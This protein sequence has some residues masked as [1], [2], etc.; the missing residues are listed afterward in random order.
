[1]HTTKIVLISGHI[2]SGKSRL[3]D[4]LAQEF[5]FHRI[6]TNEILKAY[7][8]QNSLPVGRLDLQAYG[9]QR[10]KETDEKWVLHA[11]MEAINNGEN[12]RELIVDAVHTWGQIRHVREQF[13][14]P[15]IHV[16]LT[17]SME[18]LRRRF[19]DAKNA[20]REHDK[21]LSYEQ[22]NLNKTEH[23][24]KHL[25][26]E[27]D[28]CVN[29]DRSD[30]NDT[31]VQI[32]ARI[33][34]YAP[35]SYRCVDVIVG[36]QYGSEG[37]GQIAAYLAKNYG[38]LMRVG[39]PNAGHTVKSE[40]GKYTYHH[41]PSGS[42]DSRAEV[43]I[44]PGAVIHS[45]NILKEIEECGLT[46]G[47]I[48]IDPQAMTISQGDIENERQGLV[49]VISSTGSG[50]GWAA[51]RKIMDRGKP[52]TVLARDDNRLKLFIGRSSERLEIAYSAE[53][54]ILLEGTQGSALSIHHGHYPHVTS[55]DTNAAGCLAEAG[56]S[57]AR[58]RRIIMIVRTYPIRV[59][60]PD[61]SD[62]TS[63]FLKKEITF[64][65]IAKRSG[66]NARELKKAE[67]TSTTGRDRRVGEFDWEQFRHACALNAPT[68]IALTF[69]DY[70][71][72][73]NRDARRFEQ[74][75]EETLRFIETLERVSH[76]PV[77]LISTRF[78]V[79]AVIDRR[80]WW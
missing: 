33:G 12:S 66:L 15:V 47:R 54:K 67:K 14:I 57:A 46:E 29:T 62:K 22:A 11:I 16:H 35:P 6:K 28:L 69:A 78:G 18:T 31:F 44:G 20:G 50:T 72:A 5:R 36:G 48:F 70:I 73:A 13:G 71:D 58:V 64:A 49:R 61:E 1:M 34:L 25:Q 45:E 77:S 65:E 43:L 30:E 2:C 9:D 60:D 17:A 53:K 75:T 10:D 80:D 27:A 55:R 4:R 7:A 24:I 39:G 40:N 74:L 19:E 51:A 21:A 38:V 76:A 3:A 32:A 56:I 37:K 79:R 26:Q 63:G 42:R 68:D 8:E 23:D 41:L 52:E 59:A